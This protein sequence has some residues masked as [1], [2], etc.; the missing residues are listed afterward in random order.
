MPTTAP[1]ALLRRPWAGRGRQRRSGG[2][3]P[4]GASVSPLPVAPARDAIRRQA[5]RRETRAHI[6]DGALSPEVFTLEIPDGT[7]GGFGRIARFP[8]I[9]KR[10]AGPELRAAAHQR[11][12]ARH[13]REAAA[14]IEIWL[15]TRNDPRA[16][17][18]P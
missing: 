5:R 1:S 2:L 14:L 6:P 11:S 16:A 12:A 10:V 3:Q 4:V 18:A 9:C 15:G 7:W 13:D 17:A 8:D